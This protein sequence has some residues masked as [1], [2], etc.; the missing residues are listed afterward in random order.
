MIKFVRHYGDRAGNIYNRPDVD[1][2]QSEGRN[3]ISR[4]DRRFDV[5]FLGFVDSWASVA[6]G[7]LSLSENYLYTTQAFSAYYDHL[8]PDGALVILRW[9]MDIPRLI[10]NSVVLLGARE[11]AKHI[12]VVL[13]NKTGPDPPQM[14]FM[15]R[16]RPF[17]ETETAQI[18]TNWTIAKPVVV[19]GRYV[20][21][22]YADLLSGTKTMAEYEAA[23]GRRVGPVF[24]N[25]PFYFAI[26][27]PWGM[28]TRIAK[29]L[30]YALILPVL[31]LLAVFVAFG[32]PRGQPAAPYAA[33]VVYFCCLGFGFIAVE[34]ALLQNLTLLLGHP[35]TRVAM[36]RHKATRDRAGPLS[37]TAAAGGSAPDPDG[38]RP[39]STRRS[40][41][42]ATM[43]SCCRNSYRC[44]CRSHCQRGSRLRWRSSRR[45]ALRWG[46]HFPAA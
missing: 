45:S 15:L 5:I 19:P 24:D 46:F 11:A 34:L 38:A 6:S 16:K 14:I 27:R 12:V 30:F 29:T 10:A 36:V 35:I 8:T 17:T 18:M 33:S 3:F 41:R 2:I 32:K 1:V 31:I 43:R 7:G 37:A 23:S 26:E 42:A 9:D 20:A 44:C 21:A 4:T 13:E 28:P 22:P 40:Q 25:S 39:S